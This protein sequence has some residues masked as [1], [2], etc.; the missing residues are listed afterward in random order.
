MTVADAVDGELDHLVPVMRE[1]ATGGEPRL[2]RPDLAGS[3]VIPKLPM[4]I[5]EEREQYGERLKTLTEAQTSMVGAEDGQNP[6]I[7]SETNDKI[8]ALL[9]D[10]P[11][12][13]TGPLGSQGPSSLSSDDLRLANAMW[14]ATTAPL[15]V[16]SDLASGYIDP[17]KASYAWKQYPGAQRACQAGIIDCLTN[18]LT[19]EERDM[20]PE[21]LLTQLDSTF[22]FG[23]KL[24]ESSDPFFASR[25][26]EMYKTPQE[27]RPPPQPNGV[28]K[29]PGAE[30]TFTD[31]LAG[32]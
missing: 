32:A 5:E 25:M 15:S 4:T 8:A 11:K 9:R 20:L 23:G 3:K 1:A 27:K 29:L 30:P 21:N 16:I 12:P 18:D 31:R 10:M 22:G 24:Q 6:L 2:Y 7:A 13:Q 26:S 17:D 28:L 14:E 19:Q